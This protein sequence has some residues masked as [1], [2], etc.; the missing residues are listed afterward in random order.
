V[1]SKEMNIMLIKEFPN[2]IDKYKEEID[3]QEGPETGAH[4]VYGDVLTL[5]LIN[6]IEKNNKVEVIAI[7]K[8][9]E[10]I[11]KYNI[12]YSDEVIAFSV[13]ERIEYQYRDSNLLNDNYGEFTKKILEQIRNFNS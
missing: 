8:F 4:V 10:R 3:W 2:L 7:L 9:I 5:Y 12:K 6:C 13:L 11:L 1:N